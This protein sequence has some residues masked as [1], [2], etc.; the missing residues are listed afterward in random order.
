MRNGLAKKEAKR[1]IERASAENPDDFDTLYYWCGMN[2]REKPAAAE[3]GSRRLVEMRP[4]SMR[5]LYGLGEI[6][7]ENHPE[8]REAIPYLEKTY[9]LNPSWYGP[10]YVLGRVYFKLGNLEK[11][12]KYFQ[13]SEAFTGPSDGTSLYIPIIKRELAKEKKG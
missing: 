7:L 2:T 3:A 6:I 8:P 5:A 4:N 11:A 12:L 13:A 9:L 1:L 10:I